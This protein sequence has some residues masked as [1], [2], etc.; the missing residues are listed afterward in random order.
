MR[1]VVFWTFQIAVL[2]GAAFT[3][4]L[5]TSSLQEQVIGG[6]VANGVVLA[7]SDVEFY[8]SVDAAVNPEEL[9]RL[10][11]AERQ[12]NGSPDL[13]KSAA[14]AAQAQERAQDMQAGAYYAHK[15]PTSGETFADGLRAD[16]VGYRYACENLN[17]T[18]SANASLT[19]S[20][21]LDSRDGHRECMMN[22]AVTHVGYAVVDVPLSEGEVSYIVVAIY[23][24]L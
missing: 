18:F 12:Q 9:Y 6:S 8:Q 19:M 1:D 24:S 15:N 21:W 17:M 14:L 13:L 23:A 7:D 2:C 10:T 4:W 3:L 20:D 5:L 22:Q 16:G 11:N